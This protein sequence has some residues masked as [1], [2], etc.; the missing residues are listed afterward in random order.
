MDQVIENG[1]I[2]R[3]PT[4]GEVVAGRGM[5]LDGEWGAGPSLASSSPTAGA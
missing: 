3:H 4:C 2:W 5:G 1:Q